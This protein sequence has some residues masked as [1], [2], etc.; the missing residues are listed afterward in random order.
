MLKYLEAKYED[1]SFMPKCEALL[2]LSDHMGVF[3]IL[4]FLLFCVFDM[5][6]KRRSKN[7]K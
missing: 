3:I 5:F 2:N 7:V 1:L 4:Q 6:Y